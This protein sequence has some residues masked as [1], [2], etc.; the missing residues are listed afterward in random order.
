MRFYN[1]LLDYSKYNPISCYKKGLDEKKSVFIELDQ[2]YFNLEKKHFDQRSESIFKN[3]FMN[4]SRGLFGA[5]QILCGA[6]LLLINIPR[7]LQNLHT[8]DLRSKVNDYKKHPLYQKGNKLSY[9]RDYNA[10][11]AEFCVHGLLNILKMGIEMLSLSQERVLLDKH[12]IFPYR[13]SN[14]QNLYTSADIQ[15]SIDH[16]NKLLRMNLG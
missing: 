2:F 4:F 9:I 3:I 16:M 7:S 5:Y 10:H 13:A 11:A 14:L 15:Q 6:S 12:Q 8:Y 1:H